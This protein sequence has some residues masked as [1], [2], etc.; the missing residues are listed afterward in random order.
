MTV[1]CYGAESTED[2]RAG[3]PTTRERML[4]I[5]GIAKKLGGALKKAVSIGRGKGFTSAVI[6]A[7][8]CGSRM[9]SDKTKQWIELGGIP[10]VARTLI[11][12]QECS[13]I[14]EIVLCAREDELGLYSELI[15]RYGLT[16]L[17]RVVAGGETR[18]LSALIGFKEISDE[19]ELVA[20]HDAA[21]CLVTA[22]MISNVVAAARKHGSACAVRRATDTVK[23]TDAKGFITTTLPRDTVWFAQ[24][25]QVFGVNAYRASAYTAIKEG[26]TVTDDCS[27][28]EHCDFKVA[29]VDCGSENLKITDKTDLL[30]AEAI[31]A[32]RQKCDMQ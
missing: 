26:Y 29:A 6:L 9:N 19:A 3:T 16:K 11:T 1:T 15:T 8:G 25:P 2:A 21:R 31:L 5:M 27:L 7:A 22:E 30:T 13:A 24:T 17:R 32:S 18:Q 23:Q 28:L 10:I 4:F 12:F 14:D 20:I